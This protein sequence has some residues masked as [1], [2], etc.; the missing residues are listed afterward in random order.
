MINERSTR[1]CV[2][3]TCCAWADQSN[4]TARQREPGCNG[5]AQEG[6]DFAVGA[7]EQVEARSALYWPLGALRTPDGETEEVGLGTS[8]QEKTR[9]APRTFPTSPKKTKSTQ[10]NPAGM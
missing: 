6:K 4:T 2:H 8:R 7:L 1:A 9:V 3:K 5:R 10:E